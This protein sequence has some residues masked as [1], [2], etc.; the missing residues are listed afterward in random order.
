MCTTMTSFDNATRSSAVL[1]LLVEFCT[2][3]SSESEVLELKVEASGTHKGGTTR[4][5]GEAGIYC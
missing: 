1:L 2:Q 5:G 4:N 3:I